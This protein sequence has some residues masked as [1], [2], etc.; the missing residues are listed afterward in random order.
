MGI[1]IAAFY[2]SRNSEHD[3]R[4]HCMD[5]DLAVWKFGINITIFLNAKC[6]TTPES[7]ETNFLRMVVC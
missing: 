1:W 5:Y 6:N 7:T 2:S 4:I 3:H